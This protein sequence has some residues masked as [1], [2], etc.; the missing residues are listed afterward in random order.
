[1]DFAIRAK[2]LT[3]LE[4]QGVGRRHGKCRRNQ[5]AI[6][7]LRVYSHFRISSSTLT[8]S[9]NPESIAGRQRGLGSHMLRNS[10]L[11]LGIVLLDIFDSLREISRG[12]PLPC[13]FRCRT[14]RLVDID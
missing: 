9:T 1:M 10:S 5:K 8:N 7:E 3:F 12:N 2:N 4:C 6:Y 13:G 14:R 11:G